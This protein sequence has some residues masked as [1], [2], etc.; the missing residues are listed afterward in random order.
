MKM[1]ISR[2]DEEYLNETDICESTYANGP[3]P[4]EMESAILSS[5]VRRFCGNTIKS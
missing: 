1:K 4:K 5:N 3:T 2:S